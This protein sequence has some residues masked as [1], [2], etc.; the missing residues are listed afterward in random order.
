VIFA[1]S[2]G[3]ALASAPMAT[4]QGPTYGL[5]RTPTAEELKKQKIYVLPDGHGLPAGSG[6]ADRGKVVYA[7]RCAVCH[8]PTG[9]EGPQDVLVGG[10]GTLTSNKPVK[11]IGSYWPYATTLWDN[12][13]RAMP[14]DHPGTLSPDDV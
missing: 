4:A 1:L 13:N 7:S 5:G 10:H 12:I 3:A 8:G 9:R 11:T 2:I 14:F 6:S